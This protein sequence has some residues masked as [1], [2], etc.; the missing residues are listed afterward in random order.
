MKEPMKKTIRGIVAFA[1]LLM[2]G[3]VYS[4]APATPFSL[5]LDVSPSKAKAGSKFVMEVDLT[6]NTSKPIAIPVCLGMTV[7][8]N[9]K[10][11]VRD[12]HGNSAPELESQTASVFSTAGKGIAPYETIKFSSDRLS[13]FF[14]LS[15]P[16]TYTARVSR[17]NNEAVVESNP[18]TFT[19][20]ASPQM[21][22]TGPFSLRLDVSPSN[23]KAGSNFVAEVD[24][25]NN[26][27][28]RIGIDVCLGKRVE[29]NFDIDIQDGQGNEALETRYLKAVRGEP[30]GFP[31][32]LSA[33]SIA[34][35]S[36]EPGETIKFV[37]DLPEL[38]YL[39][40]P[41]TYTV[42][43]SRS[44]NDPVVKSSPV[45][46]TVEPNPQVEA[47]PEPCTTTAD[48]IVTVS[49]PTSA[50]IPNALVVVRQEGAG[51][52]TSRL[53]V[54]RTVADGM[55]RATPLPCNAAVD[56]FVAADG[57]TP[58]T[59][60]VWTNENVTSL[61]VVLKAAFFGPY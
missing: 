59:R 42:R 45:T 27:K 35:Q 41:G 14:D 20:E 6:N 23:A 32:L 40:R 46:F 12:S 17:N 10:I 25:T 24:L 61:S 4:Q 57:L 55:T 54:L 15:R 7:E 36:V 58:Y 19:V 3:E 33:P 28:R 30:T 49:D 37:S 52:D 9:F 48:I 1:L 50:T 51:A 53:K 38:F 34:G 11:D 39:W 26:T 44:D 47:P 31:L 8:C 2:A 43:V 13:T 60:K 16:G 5:K 29:C 56:V 21:V 18:V 22:P